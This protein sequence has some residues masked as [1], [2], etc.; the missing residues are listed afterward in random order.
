VASTG[1]RRAY[2]ALSA[3]KFGAVPTGS[4]LA[5]VFPPDGCA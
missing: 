5:I 1:D 3:M 4:L 2:A